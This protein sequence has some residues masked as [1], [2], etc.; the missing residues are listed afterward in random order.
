MWYD[1]SCFQVPANL[2]KHSF[3][4]SRNFQH[5]N[6][7][8]KDF[9]KENS[10][11]NFAPKK[12]FPLR[13]E[14]PMI[15][16]LCCLKNS[17][18]ESVIWARHLKRSR[19][20]VQR[21]ILSLLWGGGFFLKAS[22]ASTVEWYKIHRRFAI[23]QIGQWYMESFKQISNI[24]YLS[25][26]YPICIRIYMLDSQNHSLWPTMVFVKSFF[27][28]YVFITS[29]MWKNLEVLRPIHQDGVGYQ[30]TNPCELDDVVGTCQPN[31]RNTQNVQ[32]MVNGWFGAPLEF[33]KKLKILS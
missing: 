33:Q 21:I 12:D 30:P 27:L 8:C 7:Q 32:L 18:S 14:E 16:I 11:R 25:I 15:M 24:Q 29:L 20:K 9:T 19:C 23:K 17:C 2:K 10:F 5:K 26:I 22:F 3:R 28:I 13:T 4:H 1:Y 31:W 6:L